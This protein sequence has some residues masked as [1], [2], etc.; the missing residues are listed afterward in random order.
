MPN[1]AQR[2]ARVVRQHHAGLVRHQGRSKTKEGD[3][4]HGP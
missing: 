2:M 1:E 4:Q 3:E